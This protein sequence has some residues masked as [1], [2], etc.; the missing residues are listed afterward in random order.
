MNVAETIGKRKSIRAYEDKSVPDE[1]L[2]KVIEAG[3]WPPNAG[4]YHMS[5]IRN[6]SLRAK[7]NDKTL[8]AMINSDNEFSRQRASLPG[9][10]PL[11]GASVLI[12][13][14]APGDSPFGAVNTALAAENMLIQA[15]E[16]GLGSCF[17]VSPTRALNGDSNKGLA[18]EAGV[19]E[20]YVVQCAI[21]VGYSADENK[22]SL[23]ERS[24]KGVV[25]YID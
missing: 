20:S 21:I 14:S 16:C 23:R 15:T 12:V 25:K 18:K 24:K 4:P 1:V 8:N 19:P 10:Q 9:Y 13:L 7:I 6:A 3:Q 2:S 5:V 17:L 11:Y 22:F